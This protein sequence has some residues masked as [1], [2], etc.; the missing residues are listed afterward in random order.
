[1]INK[2]SYNPDSQILID[3]DLAGWAYRGFDFNLFFAQFGNG[4]PTDS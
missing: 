1:M 3:F 2:G 4:F